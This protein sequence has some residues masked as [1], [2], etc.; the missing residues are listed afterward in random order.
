MARYRVESDIHLTSDWLPPEEFN[1]VFSDWSNA[2]PL[3]IEGV[4]DP[5]HEEVRIVDIDTGEVM[6]RS[7]EELFEE[8]NEP[9]L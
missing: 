4:E 6:W 3:A 5:A 9:Y 8:S 7:T 1:Q 2:V